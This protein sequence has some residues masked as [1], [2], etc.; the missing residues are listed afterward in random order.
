MRTGISRMNL[1][2]ELASQAEFNDHSTLSVRYETQRFQVKI[3]TQMGI[4][5]FLGDF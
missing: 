1:G 5:T 4:I 2:E 3:R